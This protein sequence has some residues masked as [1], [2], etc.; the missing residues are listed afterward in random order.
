MTIRDVAA[1]IFHVASN[2][3]GADVERARMYLETFEYSTCAVS[4]IMFALREQYARHQ[5]QGIAA[6]D[7]TPCADAVRDC[8][9]PLANAESEEV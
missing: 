3:S 7:G 9:I 5:A 2:P 1:N 4:A 8:L 6:V